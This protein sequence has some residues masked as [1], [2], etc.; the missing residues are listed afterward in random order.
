MIC[1]CGLRMKVVDTVFNPIEN[2]HYRKLKCNK[3]GNIIFTCECKI[4]YEAIKEEYNKYYR[5]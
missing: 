3:C 2:E 4:P 1:E 5:S